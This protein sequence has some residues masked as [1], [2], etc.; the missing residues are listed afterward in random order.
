MAGRRGLSGGPGVERA[1]ERQL[2]NWEIARTQRPARPSARREETA[3]FICISRMVGIDGRE[4][5]APLAERLGWPLFDREVLDRMAGDDDVRRRIYRAMDEHDFKWWEAAMSPWV[6]GRYVMDDYFHRLCEAVLGLARQGRCVFLGRGADLIL[7]SGH[8]LR[9]RL[10]AGLPTRIRALAASRARTEAEA[11]TAI[12]A[13]EH[14]RAEFF[15]RH[16]HVSPDDP[17]RYDLMVNRDR[18]SIEETID[19]VLAAHKHRA[20][21]LA[22]G[23][24]Q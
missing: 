11:R 3:D 4:I 23:A 5:A 13:E 7:P 6:V 24:V 12:E 10:V 2:S 20:A 8:G 9:V 18:L 14:A 19:L 15:R 22:A 17:L 16:F 1:V 21:P